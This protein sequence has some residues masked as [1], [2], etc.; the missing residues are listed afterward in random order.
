MVIN[1]PCSMEQTDSHPA[2]YLLR[3]QTPG[4]FPSAAVLGVP[5]ISGTALLDCFCKNEV[6]FTNSHENDA[7][8]HTGPDAGI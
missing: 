1:W 3:N 4:V 8:I 6:S 5:A 2:E 7:E